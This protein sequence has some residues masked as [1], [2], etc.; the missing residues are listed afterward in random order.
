MRRETRRVEVFLLVCNLTFKNSCVQKVVWHK[1]TFSTRALGLQH[2]A[3]AHFTHREGG[4]KFTVT[5]APPTLRS[6]SYATN[7]RVQTQETL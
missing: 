7:F 3:K 1:E 6:L 4:V 5:P 2:L